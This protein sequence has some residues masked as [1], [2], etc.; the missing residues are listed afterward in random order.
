MIT[1]DKIWLDE[2]SS[3]GHLVID[4]DYKDLKVSIAQLRGGIFKLWPWK[5]TY[6][7]N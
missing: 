7:A 3:Y 5:Y 1:L 2:E 6:E 4:L